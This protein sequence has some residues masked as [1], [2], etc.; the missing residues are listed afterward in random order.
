MPG[1]EIDGQGA[2]V[3]A[4]LLAAVLGIVARQG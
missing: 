1:R 3:A 2:L 4:Q